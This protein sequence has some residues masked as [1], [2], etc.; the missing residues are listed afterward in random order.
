MK[1]LFYQ[2]KGTHGQLNPV[3]LVPSCFL[4]SKELFFPWNLFHWD[5]DRG[6]S[7]LFLVFLL[8]D[9]PRLVFPH[10]FIPH[11]GSQSPW[12][13][14]S[15]LT[16]L[17]DAV[18]L[19]HEW[20][21]LN[22]AFQMRFLTFLIP[23][24]YFSLESTGNSFWLLHSS[25]L[26]AGITPVFHGHPAISCTTPLLFFLTHFQLVNPQLATEMPMVSLQVYNLTF[27]S[28]KSL[29]AFF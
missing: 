9:I 27:S 24:H 3:F 11:R 2:L 8:L 29:W 16:S 5:T 22:T 21:D 10:S 15:F 12:S 19:T 7:H 1:S 26:L 28:I 13:R 4:A 23:G 14:P 25:S 18:F 20:T 6:Q 17:Q